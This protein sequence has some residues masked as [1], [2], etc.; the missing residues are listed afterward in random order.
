MYGSPCSFNVCWRHTPG[1]RVTSYFCF[2][3]C[4]K[5]NPRRAR[6]LPIVFQL[7]SM[8]NVI[9]NI[10]IK[11]YIKRENQPSNT[12][13]PNTLYGYHNKHKYVVTWK[14]WKRKANV[15]YKHLCYIF[16]PYIY[17]FLKLF[18]VKTIHVFNTLRTLTRRS[19]TFETF[20]HDSA[21]SR[22]QTIW[23]DDSICRLIN[24][25]M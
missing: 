21:L 23:L 25:M 3:S 20:F 8:S 12:K 24:I 10:L 22:K 4:P 1:I 9:K 7:N 17:V 13:R 16:S 5:E 15:T 14:I 11:L 2:K 6:S 19:I 18:L